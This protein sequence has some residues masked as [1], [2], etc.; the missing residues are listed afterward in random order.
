MSKI[1]ITKPAKPFAF[2]DFCKNICPGQTLNTKLN[3][4]CKRTKGALI[5][6]LRLIL[7]IKLGNPSMAENTSV[8]MFAASP[9]NDLVAALL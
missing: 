2:F 9:N 4:F 6:I 7:S 5:M 8:K 1:C 3:K